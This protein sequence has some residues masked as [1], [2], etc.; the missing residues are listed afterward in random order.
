MKEYN[1]RM[2]LN[3]IR[4]KPVSRAELSDA[5]KLT[6]ASITQIVDSLIREGLVM[7]SDIVDSR[8][9]GRRQTRLMI[10]RDALC[11]A[12]VNLSAYGYDLGLAN[13]A[14]EVLWQG[15]GESN[16]RS[17]PEVLDE[18]AVRLRD[19][20]EA[21]NPRPGRIFGLGVCLPSPLDCPHADAARQNASEWSNSYISAELQ[22][23]LGW[24]VFV[25]NISNAYALDEFYFGIG[26]SG[27]ENF[28]VLR[29]DENVGTGF[30]MKG[31][32]LVGARGLSP[33]I[34]HITL[35]PDGPKCKCG[36]CGCLE[37][38]IS[39]P[40]VLKDSPYSSWKHLVDSI[41]TDPLAR[42]RFL[43]EATTLTFEIVN[44]SNVLDLDKVVLSGSLVYGGRRLA[45]IINRSMDERFTHRM[46]KNAVI[47]GGEINISRIASMPAYHAIFSPEAVI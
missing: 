23:R 24:E 12:G 47:P 11:I 27:E 15:Q 46:G 17:M 22:K 20:V 7:E 43:G 21:L 29:I 40:A 10:V 14:G 16:G 9:P 42:E 44:L 38:Y 39:V 45:E 32:L 6:R 1:R 30:I 2:V 33:E 26:C 31:R 5:T 3:C 25:D 37:N 4:S 34:G 28:M 13:L 8:R 41:D 18:I 35:V 36:N 19:A